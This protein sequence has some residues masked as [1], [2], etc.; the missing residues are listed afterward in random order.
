MRKDVRTLW[1]LQLFVLSLKMDR[2]TLP[3][4]KKETASLRRA[5]TIGWTNYVKMASFDVSSPIRRNGG[6]ARLRHVHIYIYAHIYTYIHIYIYVIIVSYCL[7]YLYACVFNRRCQGNGLFIRKS[8]LHDAD[9]TQPRKHDTNGQIR[10]TA[11]HSGLKRYV[12]PHCSI[13]SLRLVSFPVI[14][15]KG[16]NDTWQ[17]DNLRGSGLQ[18]LSYE[19]AP[20]ET[21][22]RLYLQQFGCSGMSEGWDL[23]SEPGFLRFLPLVVEDWPILFHVLRPELPWF[24]QIISII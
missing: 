23:V 2:H 15:L 24:Y 13:R 21:Q 9:N 17:P 14:G 3:P 22:A 19:L 1:S 10:P 20:L 11:Q 5:Q 4:T 6:Y 18:K 7:F 8:I 12:E 16:K